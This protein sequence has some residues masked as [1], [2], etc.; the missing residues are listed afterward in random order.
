MM[1]HKAHLFAPGE[2]SYLTEILATTDPKMQR[3]LGRT[4]PNF[5]DEVWHAHRYGIVVEGSYLKFTQDGESKGILLG[6]GERELVE[7]SPRDRIWG[8]GF[9]AKNA[10][11]RR[12]DWGL[13]LLGKALMEVR[14]RIRTEEKEGKRVNEKAKAEEKPEDEKE[15]ADTATGG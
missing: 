2:T 8:V 9:G 6:T 10:G 15:R 3:A 5:T 14:E 12:K 1:A 11:G 13:N 4:I 7:A